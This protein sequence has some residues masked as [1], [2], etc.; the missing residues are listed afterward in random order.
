[1]ML[2][3][4]I[5]LIINT[6]TAGKIPY[7]DGYY[8]RRYAVDLGIPYI[9]TL[10]AAEAAIK[11]IESVRKGEI[12]VRSLDDYYSEKTPFKKLAAFLDYGEKK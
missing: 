2:R 8:I 12:S 3:K 6:P 11:A 5:D 4:E 9:T 7:T 1:M 10:T